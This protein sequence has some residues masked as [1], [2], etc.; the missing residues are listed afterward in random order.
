MCVCVRACEATPRQASG[1]SCQAR[2]AR[3]Q[4][5]GGGAEKTSSDHGGQGLRNVEVGG[6]GGSSDDVTLRFQVSPIQ[7]PPRAGAG[8]SVL[9][10]HPK[11]VR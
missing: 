10:G 2:M 1:E 3:L 9:R 4:P 5:F 6:L 11:P 8:G 7:I